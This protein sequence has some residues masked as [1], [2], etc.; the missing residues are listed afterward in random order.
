MP[1]EVLRVALG[2]H[3]D[4]V[5][6]FDGRSLSD[7]S[8]CPDDHVSDPSI[9]ECGQD[10]LRSAGDGGDSPPFGVR[11]ELRHVV[12]VSG[13]RGPFLLT[14]TPSLSRRQDPIV[15]IDRCQP[16]PELEAGAGQIRCKVGMLGSR[17][18]LSIL[19]I[20][21]WATPARSANSR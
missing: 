11:G 2:C 5:G 20:S 9:I 16:E 7:S 8:E 19:A 4:V 15:L 1:L 14:G 3:V 18:P 6:S 13:C 17:L 21:D 10:V 12:G